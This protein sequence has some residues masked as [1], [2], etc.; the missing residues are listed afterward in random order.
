MVDSH[1]HLPVFNRQC[2]VQGEYTTRIETLL[3]TDPQPGSNVSYHLYRFVW[4][5]LFKLIDVNN[6]FFFQHKNILLFDKSNIF[7][8]YLAYRSYLEIYLDLFYLNIVNHFY[9]FVNEVIY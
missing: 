2:P 7:F 4:L 5:I 9:F 1:Y 3:R 8:V 6:F